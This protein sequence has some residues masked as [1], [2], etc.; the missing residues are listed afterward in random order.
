[1]LQ[2]VT[3][4]SDGRGGGMFLPSGRPTAIGGGGLSRCWNC[5]RYSDWRSVFRNHRGAQQPWQQRE[6]PIRKARAVARPHGK[7]SYDRCCEGQARRV[8]EGKAR[9]GV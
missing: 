3:P 6:G 9:A 2:A 5:G 8:G 4:R 7:I 1:M